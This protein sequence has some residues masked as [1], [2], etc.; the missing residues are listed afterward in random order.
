MKPTP[1][2]GMTEWLMLFALGIIWGG[3]F[4]LAKVAVS[5]V[6]PLTLVF[7]RVSVAALILITYLKMTGRNFPIGW[8]IWSA[9]LVMGLI[10]NVI[11]FS[12]LFWGQIHIASGLA[13]IL[14]ATTPIFTVLVAHLFTSDE[15]IN[16]HRLLGIFLGFFGVA[17]M[18]GSGL[19]GDVSN[20]PLPM[21]A[22]LGA[23]VSYAF[24]GV[25]GRRFARMGVGPVR[26][27]M[28]QLSGSSLI[29]LPAV[30]LLD[31]TIQ[32]QTYSSPVLWSVLGLAVVCTALAYIL[33]FRILSTGGATNLSLVTLIVPA[34]AIILGTIFL[35]EALG[36]Y[37]FLGLGFIAMGLVA[38][39]GR[40]LKRFSRSRT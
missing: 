27:A 6:P 11:P 23:A 12:L 10:N 2:L 29:M 25:F 20:P 31:P 39:D 38:T 13:S 32:P 37:E 28:G 18:L 33:F 15:K 17:V 9:F 26:V 4:F 19:S 16:W 24:A 7:Y 30:L 5:E 1:S 22:C 40:L 3:S 36:L 8:K 35:Q 21:I 34:S 14:N